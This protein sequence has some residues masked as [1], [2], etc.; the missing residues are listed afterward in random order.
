MA[1]HQGYEEYQYNRSDYRYH[2]E[3]NHFVLDYTGHSHDALSEQRGEE[4][5]G[6]TGIANGLISWR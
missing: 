6:W 2:I 5:A 3:G 1:L 4:V